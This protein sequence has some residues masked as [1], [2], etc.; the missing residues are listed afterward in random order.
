ME[1]RG[2]ITVFIILGVVLVVVFALVLFLVYSKGTSQDQQ[3]TD[4]SRAPVDSVKL[5]VDNCL[6]KVTEEGAKFVAERGGY[7]AL[8]EASTT[9]ALKNAPYYVFEGVNLRPL[10][11]QV[12][13]SLGRYVEENLQFCTQNFVSFPF[14]IEFGKVKAN[15]V[16][17][18][19]QITMT[20]NFPVSVIVGDARTDLSEF[21]VSL[22]SPLGL[23]YAA[24]E[25]LVNSALAFDG[26][27]LDC[28][29]EVSNKYDLEVDAV[30]TSPEEI[31]F[32]L[33]KEELVYRFAQK[34][35]LKEDEELREIL[36]LDNN[37][38]EEEPPVFEE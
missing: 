27:C 4:V 11:E 6:W 37:L 31:F 1:K 21:Q 5:Y 22:D 10:K 3:A 32:I 7:Y 16:L 9:D 24:S 30:R 13:R 14:T 29:E 38:G 19:Q 18:V 36:G 2:Q 33:S 12:E 26:L 34:S 23:M 35:V 20:V 17:D 25:D 15:P 28:L 8:P